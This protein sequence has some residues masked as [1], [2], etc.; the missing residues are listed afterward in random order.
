MNMTKVSY[1]LVALADF[2]HFIDILN[3]S[4]VYIIKNGEVP[5]WDG[6]KIPI[7]YSSEYS[8]LRLKPPEKSK[9][10]S[11]FPPVVAER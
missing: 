7:H 3:R 9:S 1:L 6:M 2:L 4:H 5:G 10:I 11:I 8:K